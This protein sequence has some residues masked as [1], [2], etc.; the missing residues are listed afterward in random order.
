MITDDSTLSTATQNLVLLRAGF[1]PACMNT[2]TLNCGFTGLGPAVGPRLRGNRTRIVELYTNPPDGA[3]VVCADELE[4]ATLYASPPA[5]ACR[6]TDTAS[7]TIDYSRSPEK[8]LS[9]GALRPRDGQEIAIPAPSRISVYY[10]QLQ[11]LVEDAK[12]CGDIYV[13]I[14]NLSPITAHP[15]R[16]TGGPPPHHTRI[17]PGRRVPAQ[18]AGGL[19]APVSQDRPC[20]ALVRRP[21]P[22]P[23]HDPRRYQAGQLPRPPVDLGQSRNAHQALVPPVCV[24]PLRNAATG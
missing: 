21:R 24:H 11:Q 7:K 15:P 20:R 2:H 19:A 13:I 16:L 4:P 1:S 3:P 14:D 18:P 10:Q 12:S 9:Y 22:H 6:R 17:H 5:P 8:T 23:P